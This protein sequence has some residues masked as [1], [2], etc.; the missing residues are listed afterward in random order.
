MYYLYRHIRL[1]KNEP[2]YIGIGTQKINRCK[3][4]KCIFERAYSKY[5]RNSIWNNIIKKT[6]YDIE[7]IYFSNDRMYI[8]EKEKEFIKLY[9]RINLGTGTLANLTDGGELTYEEYNTYNKQLEKNSSA[10]K[11]LQYDLEGNFIREWDCIKCIEGFNTDKIK[12]CSLRNKNKNYQ[13][14]IYRTSQNY[15]WLKYVNNYSLK[16]KPLPFTN[17]SILR[18]EIIIQTDLNGNIIEIYNGQYKCAKKLNINIQT[19]KTCI[20]SKTKRMIQNKELKNYKFMRKEFFVQE[21]G[22][23]PLKTLIDLKLNK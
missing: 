13:S 18:S 3:T 19:L 16:I 15:I 17:N 20:K 6:K 22:M 8:G 1:D 12:D 21:F 11:C 14:D 7:I 2:F 23:E 9:G 10:S 4:N 5:N